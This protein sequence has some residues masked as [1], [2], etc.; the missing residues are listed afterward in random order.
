MESRTWVREMIRMSEQGESSL[1][2]IVHG[3]LHCERAHGSLILHQVTE[4]LVW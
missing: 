4:V 3:N 1:S 2:F